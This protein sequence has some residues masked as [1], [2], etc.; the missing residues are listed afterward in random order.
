MNEVFEVLLPGMMFFWVLFAGQGPMQEV[1]QEK[2]TH[3]L[4][5]ILAAPVTVTQ[6]VISKMA[7][8]FLL[9]FIIQALLLLLSALLFGI[10][11]GNPLLL[12]ISIAASSFSMTGFLG[13]IYSLSK[14]K[15][16]SNVI[17]PL[18]ILSC[19]MVGG[20]MFP[21]QQ[22]PLFIQSIGRFT[23][24]RWSIVALEAV[25]KAKPLSELLLPFGFLTGFGLVASLAAFA[26]FQRQLARE[27]AR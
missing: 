17:V 22:L 8:C 9:C 18:A 3:T 5:R 24:N 10:H 16:Q 4:A 27:G 19:A 26:L 21:F 23:P 11:W 15:E 20:C 25:T 6:F 7:R 12:V 2:E 1:L 14:T 13:F